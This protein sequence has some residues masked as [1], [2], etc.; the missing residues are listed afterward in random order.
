MILIDANVVLAAYRDDHEFH[1]VARPWFERLTAGT[2]SFGIPATVWA[3]VLRLA[4]NRRI[5]LVPSRVDEVFAFVW[6]TVTAPHHRRLE[7]GPRHLELLER[8]CADARVSSDLVNDAALAA[9]A[10]ENGASVASF[11]D[12]FARFPNLRW[13]IPGD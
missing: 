11:D 10:I 9:I 13:A 1:P 2:E 7:P 8:L 5:F 6:A 3:T 12:D 4:T